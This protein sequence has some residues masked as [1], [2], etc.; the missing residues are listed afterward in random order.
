M[1]AILYR[2]IM[3][4]RVRIEPTNKG[5]AV[6]TVHISVFDEGD[7]GPVTLETSRTENAMTV[8]Q[9]SRL[10]ARKQR[11]ELPGDQFMQVENRD[12]L[13]LEV[14]EWMRIRVLDRPNRSSVHEIDI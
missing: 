2:N 5:L 1:I 13:G 9:V 6:L 12:S 3:E 7:A 11:R 4:A 10:S 8:E 14:S